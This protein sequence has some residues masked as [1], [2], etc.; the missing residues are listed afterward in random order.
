M[1][2]MPHITLVT[3]GARSGKSA[4]AERLCLRLPGQP[5]YI[6][7]AEAHDDEMTQ[8]IALHRDR[9]GDDWR[10]VEAPRDLAAALRATD[11]QG[12]R[13]VDCL[14]M[15][16]ANGVGPDDIDDLCAAL[17]DMHSP[18]VLV[19]NELGN[20]IVPMNAMARAFR[21]DHGRINQAVAAVA[22]HVWM[23]VCGLPMRIKPGRHGDDIF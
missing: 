19:T 6:A 18:V 10:T 8:R 20:G 17:V 22:G 11:G 13:L 15:W 1:K 3:G 21:D 5:V 2:D 7:T 4:L 16:L 23:A 12:V 14:T 9:R